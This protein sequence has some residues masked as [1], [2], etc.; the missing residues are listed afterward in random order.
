MFRMEHPITQEMANY[1]STGQDAHVHALVR[2]SHAPAVL[3]AVAEPDLQAKLQSL[4]CAWGHPVETVADGNG[5]LRALER[6]ES[7]PIV[8][9]DADLPG[10]HGMSLL[11]TL[12]MQSTRRRRWTVLL[13]DA[14]RAAQAAGRDA[15]SHSQSRPEADAGVDDVLAKP[16]DEFELRVSLRAASRLQA[17]F[18]EMADALEAASFQATRDGLTGLLNREALLNQLFQETDRTLRLGSQL[19]FLLLDLDQFS[20]VNREHGYDGGD[21]VLRQLASRFRR[22]LRSYD[23]T[24]RCGGDQFLVAMPGCTHEDARSMAARLRDCVS[25]RPFD[26]L[27]AKVAMTASIGIAQ[28]GGRSPLVV[29]REAELALSRAKLAGGACARWFPSAV[30]APAAAAKLPL[31]SGSMPDAAQRQASPRS[32]PV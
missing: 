21:R 9:L 28:S 23:V 1:L 17:R 7:V 30:S 31:A 14:A 4:I 22:F 8:V 18:A 15:A 3:L 27:Q 25:E 32:V 29:L 10:L 5:L 12:Q 2:S 6:P 26:I 13:A 24:G 16:V 19:A 20:R 11:N